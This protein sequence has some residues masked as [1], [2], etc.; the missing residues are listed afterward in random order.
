MCSAYVCETTWALLV[1]LH[2]WLVTE[3]VWSALP[4]NNTMPSGHTARGLLNALACVAGPFTVVWGCGWAS[5][6]VVAG[7]E[8]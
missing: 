4:V 2:E 1:T 8:R 5:G 6:T 3:F 7:V